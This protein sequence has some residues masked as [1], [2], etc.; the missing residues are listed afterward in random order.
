MASDSPFS[1]PLPDQLKEVSYLELD[2]IVR[3]LV[4]HPDLRVEIAAHT[5]GWLSHSLSLQLSEQRA[6]AIADHLLSCV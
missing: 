5:N 1:Q 6:Q 2:R 4:S 3:F